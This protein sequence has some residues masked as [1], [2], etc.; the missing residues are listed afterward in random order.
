MTKEKSS[1]DD[2]IPLIVGSACLLGGTL[3]GVYVVPE[4]IKVF[5]PKPPTPP[6]QNPIPNPEPEEPGPPPLQLRAKFTKGLSGPTPFQSPGRVR[7]I[8]Y[9][10]RLFYGSDGHGR[11]VN[12]EKPRK[13]RWTELE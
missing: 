12:L 2:W 3:L 9:D 7:T 1:L 5:S 11:T 4:V 10:K 13:M 8:P 6:P